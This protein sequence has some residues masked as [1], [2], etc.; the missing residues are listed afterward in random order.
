LMRVK[1]AYFHFAECSLLSVKVM[2]TRAKENL[3]SLCRMQLTFCK[4]NANESK[5]KL[6]FT[7]PSAAYFLQN[8]IK[9]SE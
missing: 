3:F 8:Y 7:L 9:I 2:Q 1:K 5:R 4:S 6:V